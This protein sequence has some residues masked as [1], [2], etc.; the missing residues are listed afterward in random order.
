MKGIYM[1]KRVSFETAPSVFGIIDCTTHMKV[2]RKKDTIPKSVKIIG[3]LI[4]KID[5]AIKECF[6][7]QRGVEAF[8]KM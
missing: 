3:L 7:M 4:S 2:S 6:K 5:G 1:T 8:K